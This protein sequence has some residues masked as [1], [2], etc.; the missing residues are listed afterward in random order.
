[1][2]QVYVTLLSRQDVR[3]LSQKHTDC[4]SSALQQD[5]SRQKLRAEATVVPNCTADTLG[6]ASEKTAQER[7]RCVASSIFS[8]FIILSRADMGNCV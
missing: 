4:R 6:R 1:M 8:P 3:S 7:A 2:P 5:Y